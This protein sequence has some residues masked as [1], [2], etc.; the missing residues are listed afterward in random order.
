MNRLTLTATVAVLMFSIPQAYAVDEHHPDKPGVPAKAAPGMDT[1][2]PGGKEAGMPMAM[3]QKNMMKM[4]DM[5][6]R[7]HN[8]KDAKEREKLMQEHGQIMQENM[9]MMQGMM[10]GGMM[11]D[12]AKGGMMGH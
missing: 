5:M 10:G 4:H 7:I 6:H 9:K 11:G 2:A 3:M 8:A 12:G 1:K